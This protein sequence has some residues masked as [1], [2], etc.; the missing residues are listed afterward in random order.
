MPVIIPTEPLVPNYRQR[1]TI[2]GRDYI[3]V[4]RHN[5]RTGRWFMDIYDQDESLIKGGVKLVAGSPL[6]S[7]VRDVRMWPGIMM[8]IDQ[9]NEPPG[10]TDPSLCNLGTRFLLAYATGDEV[11][12]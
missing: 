6:A 1:T 2:D 11:V 12:A 8:V 9:E 7:Y 5:Q 4:F 10:P 3:L